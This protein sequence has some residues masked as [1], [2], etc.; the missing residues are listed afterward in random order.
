MTEDAEITVR[1]PTL[2]LASRGPLFDCKTALWERLEL[3]FPEKQFARAVLPARPS[4][5]TWKRAFTRPPMIGIAWLGLTPQ[6]E[7]GR[8]LRA[9]SNWMLFFVCRNPKPE[10]LLTGDAYGV[11]MLGL[12]GLASALLHDWTVPGLGTWSIR[13]IDNA[14]LQDFIDEELGVVALEVSCDLTVI[15]VDAADALPEFLRLGAQWTLPLL[16]LETVTDV[17]QAA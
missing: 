3:G 10:A 12:A 6:K 5:D 17:R 14:A 8:K 13:T 2:T 9:S 15:D 4:A 1:S 7:S 16:D 11:G